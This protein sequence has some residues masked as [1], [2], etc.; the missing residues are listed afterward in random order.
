MYLV[1]VKIE[2]TIKEWLA[3]GLSGAS[4]HSGRRTA[5]T[6]WASK[7]SSFAI[8]NK[9]GAWYRAHGFS[10]ASSHIGRRIAMRVSI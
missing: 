1:R 3:L 8:L 4:S 9:F 10:G 6:H 5:T 2:D 7:S